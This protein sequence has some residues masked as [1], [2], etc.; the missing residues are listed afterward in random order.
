MTSKILTWEFGSESFDCSK[1]VIVGII[2]VTPD[3]FSDGGRFFEPEDAIRQGI[4]LAE[5]GADILDIGGESTRPGSDPVSEAEELR[6]VIPVIEGIRETGVSAPISIDTRRIEVARKA[7]EAGATI[8]NDVSAFRDSTELASFC[9]ENKLGVVLMHMLGTPRNMQVDPHYDD[10]IEEIGAFFEE[11]MEFATSE[12]IPAE[13]IVLDPGIGFG[14]LLEH[15]LRI[16]RECFK[17]MKLGRPIMIGPSRK[18]FIG[19]LLDVEVGER[20]P[21]TIGACVTAYMTG[22]RVFRVHDVV[23]IK[24][25]LEVA[26]SIITCKAAVR[27]NE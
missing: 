22:A 19:E 7:V 6:R 26:Y 16:L 15:N 18:R 21:G 14:K 11:R 5:D 25:A 24:H 8:V 20:L 9:A 27:K 3:S 12:G 4:A 10:V 13:R 17:W 23:P 1:P 2:N